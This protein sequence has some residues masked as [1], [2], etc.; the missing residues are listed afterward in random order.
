MCSRE[1]LESVLFEGE[2]GK[3]KIGLDVRGFL[4]AILVGVYLLSSFFLVQDQSIIKINKLI[5]K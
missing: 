4:L 2:N 3:G 5:N 1:R